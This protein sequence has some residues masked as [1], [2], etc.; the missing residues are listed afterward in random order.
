MGDW[1]RAGRYARAERHDAVALDAAEVAREHAASLADPSLPEVLQ[2]VRGEGLRRARSRQRWHEHRARG[3]RERIERVRACGTRVFRIACTCCGVVGHEP[4]HDY[5]GGWRYCWPCRSRR[6]ARERA[7]L[8]AGIEAQRAVYH[9]Y[10]QHA[11]WRDKLLTLTVPHGQSVASDIATLHR[12]WV[13][14]RALISLELRGLPRDLRRLPYYRALEVAG[15]DHAHMHAWVLSPFV[16][17][18][19]LRFLWGR[20]LTWSSDNLD[21]AY[22]PVRPLSDVL[23]QYGDTPRARRAIAACASYR[24]KPLAYLPWPVLDVR[25]CRAGTADDVAV[26]VVK[27]LTKDCTFASD[28][29]PTPIPAYDYAQIAEATEGR[30]QTCACT[31]F[32]PEP[33]KSACT[34]CGNIGGQVRVSERELGVAPGGPRGPPSVHT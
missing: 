6:V 34:E 29:T 5:C 3:Q 12:S 26:E 23:A 25:M 8:H 24:R 17:H 27:Y 2:C 18:V 30:R 1:T 11:G 31:H 19:T 20:A 10:M 28:G 15:T 32:A 22:V 14:F 33:E 9:R 4:L 13:R 16:H 21:G 7:K